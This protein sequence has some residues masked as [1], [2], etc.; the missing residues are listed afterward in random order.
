MVMIDYFI[1]DTHWMMMILR[2]SL[3]M[4][5]AMHIALWFRN[6]KIDIWKCQI[7][8]VNL[9]FWLW[10][11]D[12][13]EEIP[14]IFSLNMNDFK[15]H[16][17]FAMNSP[18]MLWVYDYIDE[19]IVST[20]NTVLACIGGIGQVWPGLRAL[21]I[22][23]MRCSRECSTGRGWHRWI[24][25]ESVP[26]M[27]RMVG[28]TLGTVNLELLSWY[29]TW[30]SS[31]QRQGEGLILK[32]AYQIPWR[33]QI[34]TKGLGSWLEILEAFPQRRFLKKL[35]SFTFYSLNR[36]EMV[37]AYEICGIFLKLWYDYWL[38]L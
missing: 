17:D 11:F 32:R 23:I 19:T 18:C 26:S 10:Y 2:L 8:I 21:L 34:K 37:F 38:E 25:T 36:I 20:W 16:K 7:G 13:N 30:L 1:V 27:E 35:N 29:T 3:E 6:V 14:Q 4:I 33:F 5:F 31:S 9:K 12:I 22:M 28:A 24:Y 15:S